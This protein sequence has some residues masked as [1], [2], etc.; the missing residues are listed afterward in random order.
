LDV[1]PLRVRVL[2]CDAPAHDL[3]AH[4]GWG[5]WNQ[6]PPPAAHVAMLRSWHQRFAAE[7]AFIGPDTLELS[8]A[9]PPATTAEL[10]ELAW[11]QYIYCSD[12]VHQGAG[13]LDALARELC[14][15]PRWFFWWD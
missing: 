10:R 3:P 13:S 7:L 9:R 1:D 5:G 11:E 8:V 4:L 2:L 14:G 15:S 12:I 6:C